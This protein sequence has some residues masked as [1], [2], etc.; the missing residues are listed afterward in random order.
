M[1]E[2]YLLVLT[3]S[4]H[5]NNHDIIFQRAVGRPVQ[6]LSYFACCASTYSFAV[7]TRRTD[8]L[9]DEDALEIQ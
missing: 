1:L 6:L 9:K 7:G 5:N 8:R 4:D 3:V 2:V